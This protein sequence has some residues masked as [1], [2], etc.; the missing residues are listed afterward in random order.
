MNI[1]YTRDKI[2][3]LTNL[4][5]FRVVECFLCFFLVRV[6]RVSRLKFKELETVRPYHQ[7]G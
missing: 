4:I 5:A 2:C 3:L 1:I 7:N 6:S